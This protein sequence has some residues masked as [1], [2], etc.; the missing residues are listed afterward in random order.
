MGSSIISFSRET[1]TCNKKQ[2]FII[3]E[4]SVAPDNQWLERFISFWGTA[5]FQVHSLVLFK[6][7]FT[8]TSVVPEKI[9]ELLGL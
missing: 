1:Q 2:Q 8:G 4:T 9:G 3:P 7:T 6:G 5:Y